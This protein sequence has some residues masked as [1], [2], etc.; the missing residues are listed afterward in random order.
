MKIGMKNHIKLASAAEERKEDNSPQIFL[1]Y[2]EIRDY[3][4]E[5]CENLEIEDYSLQPI[6]D[7]SPAKWHLAHTSWFFETFF[8]KKFDPNYVEFNEFFNFFF[9]SYYNGVGA[10]TKRCERGLLSRPTVK[11]VY[12]FRNYID[13]K[14]KIFLLSQLDN[15]QLE[16]IELGLQHE[17][18][19]QELLITDLKYSLSINPMYPA[20]FNIQENRK[21]VD[22]PHWV[23]FNKGQYQIGHNKDTFCYDNEQGHHTVY[24]QDF[25]IS[26]AL[27]TNRE[28][29]EF[30]ESKC[31]QNPLVWLSDGWDWVQKEEIAHPLYWVRSQNGWKVYTLDGLKDLEPDA[32]VTHISYY[33]AAAYAEWR[34]MRLP[35]EFEW[36]AACKQFN[37]GQRWE[38]TASAYLPYPGFSKKDGAI[39]EYNGKFMI[40]LMVLRGASIATPQS[41]KR[42]TYRNFFSPHLRWQFTGIRLCK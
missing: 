30:I 4:E 40:N 36:E 34:G 39:G 22:L 28:Y 41:H 15:L 37:W 12:E 17:Q 29:I 26:T 9:N 16:I 13:D 10:R 3:T 38:W 35:S 19:H 6:V 18:Q 27:V 2:K 33:E 14:M 20:V 8:L 23:Q 42:F 31:Y 32:P 21:Q 25:Q 5:I 7:V 24:L 1:C 11:E